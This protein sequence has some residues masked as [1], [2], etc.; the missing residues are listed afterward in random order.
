MGVGLAMDKN[1]GTLTVVLGFI[2]VIVFAGLLFVGWVFSGYNSLVSTNEEVT[3]KWSQVENN[4]QRRSDLIPNLVNT[5]KG[6]T[7][8]EEK[9]FSEI[10]D[11]RSKLMGA[12][13]V[14][15]K[16]KADGELSNA[17]SRL[18]VITE[19]YPDLKANAQYTQLMDELAGT[20]NRIAV[21][22]RDYNESVK[23]YNLKVKSLPVSLVAGSMG[24]SEKTYFEAEEGAKAV[25]KVEF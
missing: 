23:K 24:F 25:P 19:N 3:S 20:E 17:L 11:A 21:S 12:K 9:V 1:K 18:M 15:E 14:D 10:A 7:K 6:Y 16:A 5:V 4:M 2:G 22:R 8:H 13:S